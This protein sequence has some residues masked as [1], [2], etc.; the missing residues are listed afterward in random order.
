MQPLPVTAATPLLAAPA[1]GVVFEDGGAGSAPPEPSGWQ[2]PPFPPRDAFAEAN[3]SLGAAAAEQADV[4]GVRPPAVVRLEAE[5]VHVVPPVHASSGHAAAAAAAVAHAAAAA[6]LRI[7]LENLPAATMRGASPAPG[8]GDAERGGG[9][10]PA[11]ANSGGGQHSARP[12][13]SNKYGASPTSH[14]SAGVGLGRP[15]SGGLQPELRRR[16]AELLSP[17]VPGGAQTLGPANAWRVRPHTSLGG[18][19]RWQGG[20]AAPGLAP[21]P[22]S[23][24]VSVTSPSGA[25]LGSA[26]VSMPAMPASLR[27]VH[28]GMLPQRPVTPGS[29]PLA[30]PRAAPELS[31]ALAR[32]PH[33]DTSYSRSLELLFPWPRDRRRG[34]A[35][36]EASPTAAPPASFRA[37]AA[38][39][40][41]DAVNAVLSMPPPE[42]VPFR[43]A[44]VKLP[45]QRPASAHVRNARSD[46]DLGFGNLLMSGHLVLGS[47]Y[48]PAGGRPASARPAALSPLGELLSPFNIRRR[49]EEEPPELPVFQVGRSPR[50]GVRAAALA[51]GAETTA[52]APH[53][54]PAS[55]LYL[56]HVAVAVNKSL[57]PRDASP[58]PAAA[59][60]PSQ[61]GSRPQSARPASAA[62]GRAASAAAAAPGG[63]GGRPSLSS[64]AIMEEAGGRR[65]LQLAGMGTTEWLPS[66][67]LARPPVEPS[68]TSTGSW[69]DEG[70]PDAWDAASASEGGGSAQPTARPPARP[71]TAVR[72][73]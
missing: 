70:P 13:S 51:A 41:V 35:R 23:A 69:R 60:T 8:G 2:G 37:P 63:G 30:T 31:V 45:P 40:A 39:A 3:A 24:H 4:A 49:M 57:P 12:R 28:A 48:A 59:A 17:F 1:V 22:S 21:G 62:A 68:Y 6:Q 50:A 5:F 46:L 71:N 20:G 42:V 11:T 16:K 27:G 73:R 15:R 64:A 61:R 53:M 18:G 54:A 38:A 19:F 67:A 33:Q 32:G 44:L 58:A 43:G 47:G 7:D 65:P 14:L 9:S 52:L 66:A 56:Q 25:H 26:V 72:A 36:G 10:R 29:P 34:D 55:P